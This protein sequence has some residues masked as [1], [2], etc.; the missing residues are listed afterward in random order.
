MNLANQSLRS[1][2]VGVYEGRDGKGT[3]QEESYPR[4]EHMEHP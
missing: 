4:V 3:D 1:L 2:V